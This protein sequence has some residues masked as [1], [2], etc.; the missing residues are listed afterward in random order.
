MTETSKAGPIGAAKALYCR[1]TDM[2]NGLQGI[3]ALAARLVM[4]RMFLK[5]GLLKLEDFGTA[6]D[7]FEYEYFEGMPHGLAIVAGAFATFGETVLPLMLIVGFMTRFASAG[8]LIMTIIIVTLVYPF[9][10]GTGISL[11]WNDHVWWTV[12]LL[13]LLAYGPGS[14]SLDAIF[15]KKR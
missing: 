7:L 15:S 2:A 13:A 14:L 9:W 11:W 8:L 4:A 1:F 6:V 5:S 10:S 3:A 12:I